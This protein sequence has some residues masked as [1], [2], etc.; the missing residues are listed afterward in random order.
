MDPP[1]QTFIDIIK[2][3]SLPQDLRAIAINLCLQKIRQKTK[4]VSILL[5]L[6]SVVIKS[7]EIL[8]THY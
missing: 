4:T 2:D 1:L 6:F 3:D 5:Y 7:S 8:E